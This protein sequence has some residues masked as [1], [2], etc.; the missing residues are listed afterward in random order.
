MFPVLIGLFI[1]K[2]IIFPVILKAL[3]IMSAASLVLS[4]MSLLTTIMLGFKWFL[5]HNHNNIHSKNSDS[6]VEILHLPAIKK[7]GTSQ[8]DREIDNKY[9]VINGNDHYDAYI[10]QK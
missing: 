7:K 8:W 5:T 4:K 10:E 3:T 2:V 9:H 6:K 1:A